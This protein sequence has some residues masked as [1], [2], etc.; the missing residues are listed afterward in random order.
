MRINTTLSII[1]LAFILLIPWLGKKDFYTRGEPREALVMQNILETGNWVL[2][3][4]YG[5]V[6]P[7]KP[8]LMH[9]LSAAMSL[10]F[11]EVTEFVSRLPSA[12][13]ALLFLA[14]FFV[15]LKKRSTEE[16]SLFSCL[17]LLTSIEW[18]IA[19]SS[20]RVDMLLASLVGIAF[21][22]LFEWY[23]KAFQGYPSIA[24]ICL[25][26][27]T[28]SK[29]P[30]AV[31]LPVGVL[32]LFQLLKGENFWRA[33]GRCLKVFLPALVVASSW[34]VLAAVQRPEAFVDKVYYENVQ[35]FMGTQEDE[36]HKHSALFLYATVLLGLM[37]WP[38][39]AFGSMVERIKKLRVWEKEVLKRWFN[40]LSPLALYFLTAVVCFVVFFSIPAGKRSVYLLP[41]YPFLAYW[42]ASLL[43]P[44][45]AR[46]AKVYRIFSVGLS[47][48]LLILYGFCALAVCCSDRIRVLQTSHGAL[49][50]MMFYIEAIKL[51]LLSANIMDLV[52][53][54]L[55]VL[56]ILLA[57]IYTVV[58]KKT[59][60]YSSATSVFVLVCVFYL[61]MHAA[62]FPLF[63]NAVSPKEYAKQLVHVLDR[64]KGHLYSFG[65]TQYGLSFYLN[66]KIDRFEDTDAKEGLVLIDTPDVKEF[67]KKIGVNGKLEL[68][69][70]SER[71]IVKPKNRVAL[72]KFL[73]G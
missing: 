48:L 26:L 29:G 40:T 46:T 4:G 19:A 37:P 25:A 13:G 11:G 70:I 73:V 9:W 8:P 42:M 62:I 14:Y 65:T 60:W 69:L 55:P 35:R 33:T 28:L 36:P 47:L 12:I 18:F 10:P 2:P 72:Y 57:G 3:S 51:W 17:I 32:G 59:G 41:I 44:A 39:L 1:L 45:T 56:F 61:S 5:G 20:A 53:L 27:A 64:E 23:E 52:L 22:R 67:Q 15:F 49:S 43:T 30:V 50:D 16:I 58:K 63:A 34:Y 6:V 66:R 7:S 68:L 38:L 31:I 21:L 24:V 71:G 54:F